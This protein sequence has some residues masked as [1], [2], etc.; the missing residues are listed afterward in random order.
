M[1]RHFG[2]RLH[3]EHCMYRIARACIRS[4]RVEVKAALEVLASKGTEGPNLPLYRQHLT[5]AAQYV[6]RAREC[7]DWARAARNLRKGRL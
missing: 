1:A 5:Y 2:I 6:Y 4:A 3:D 7:R